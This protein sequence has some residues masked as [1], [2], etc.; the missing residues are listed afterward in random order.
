MEPQRT[1]RNTLCPKERRSKGRDITRW[2]IDLWVEDEVIWGDR[3]M[4][5]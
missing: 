1:Q 5:Y 3:G 2:K 4:N